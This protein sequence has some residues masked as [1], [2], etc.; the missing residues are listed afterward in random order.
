MEGLFTEEEL[1]SDNVKDKESKVAYLTKLIEVV[2]KWPTIVERYLYKLNENLFCAELATGSNLSARPSKIVAGQEPTKTNELLQAIGKA[3]D[4]KVRL[5]SNISSNFI[6]Y[7][8]LHQN[9]VK[10]YLPT[11]AAII[12]YTFNTFTDK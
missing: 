12:N 3:L 1:N 5:K 9:S 8:N 10:L 4:K 7:F 6:T 2:S 11:Q